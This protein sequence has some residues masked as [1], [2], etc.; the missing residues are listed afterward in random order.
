MTDTYYVEASFP[1][2]QVRKEKFKSKNAA[3][4]WARKIERFC[5]S[6]KKYY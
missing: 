2:G 1:N 4:Y 5:T 3:E 6:V